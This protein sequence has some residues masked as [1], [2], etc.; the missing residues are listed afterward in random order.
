MVSSVRNPI[1]LP[2][3]PKPGAL[4]F[5]VLFA[6][7]SIARAS[8]SAVVSVQAYDL[9]QSSQHV[10]LLFTAVGMLSLCGTLV[11]P[12]LIRW[13][14]RRFAYT[15]GAL[16][17]ITAAA[18]FA[19]FTIGGQVAAMSVRIF[20][21]ACLNVTTSLYI[22][23]HIRKADLVRSEPLRL[24][25]STVSW[26]IGP[27]LGVWLYTGYG[28][29]APQVFS[30]A[31]TVVLLGLFWYLRLS[32][33]PAIKP[34][35]SQAGN[36]LLSVRRFA[37]QPR[38]RLAW[39]IAFGRSCFWSS[40]FIYAPLLMITSGLGKDAGGLLVSAGNAVLITAVLFGRVAERVSVRTVIVGAFIGIAI[41]T[42]GAGIAGTGMPVVAAL[43]LLAASV[44]AAALDSVGGIPFLRSVRYHE[45]AEMTGVYRTYIDIA[46]LLPPFLYSLIL[47]FFPLGSVFVVL[48]FW[49]LVC[50]WFAWR[51]MP[52]SM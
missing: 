32:E 13:T 34:G 18:L 35:A 25:F 46:D 6:I 49:S 3:A 4:A 28:V 11:V 39:L 26:T 15:F 30:A 23:D 33:N 21:A 16:C 19:T 48:G 44:G 7:E 5:G 24:S 37:A 45:R 47:F 38:L 41:T 31:C 43:L 1:W 36:P 12:L 42:I 50:A 22:L 40:F 14:A 2:A 27:G 52:K 29:W 20:G 17:L 8:I 10:S 9:L 51:Y